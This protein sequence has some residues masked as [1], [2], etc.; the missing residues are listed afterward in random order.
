MTATSITSEKKDSLKNFENIIK[1]RKENCV[2]K[3]SLKYN[4]K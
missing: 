3:G 2:H 1:N 4:Q